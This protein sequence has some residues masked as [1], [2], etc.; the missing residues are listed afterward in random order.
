[1]LNIYKTLLTCLAVLAI[2]V[3][4]ASTAKNIYKYQDENGIWHFTD[5]APVDDT[6]FETVYMEREPEPRIRMRQEGS[7]QS[8]VYLVFNDYW[9]PVEV[10][11]SLLD[12]RNVISEPLVKNA[13]FGVGAPGA[14]R[15]KTRLISCE[16]Q[17]E[18]AGKVLKPVVPQIGFSYA[19]N[20]NGFVQVRQLDVPSAN[21]AHG[22]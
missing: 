2:L 10:E 21:G 19:T 18:R 6:E 15:M 14:M 12:A 8:P 13:T 11:L 22:C 17:P 20:A 16:E 4:T 1:M 7:K 5:R 9:G 3:P